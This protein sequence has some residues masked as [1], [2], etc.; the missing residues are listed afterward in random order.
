MRRGDAGTQVAVIETRIDPLSI[1]TG[2]CCC[3]T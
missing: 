1:S 3:A 2:V